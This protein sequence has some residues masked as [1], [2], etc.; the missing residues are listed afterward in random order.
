MR[1]LFSSS[2]SAAYPCGGSSTICRVYFH[3]LECLVVVKEGAFDNSSVLPVGYALRPFSLWRRGPLRLV[4]PCHAFQ[5]CT[6]QLRPLLL[7]ILTGTCVFSSVDIFYFRLVPRS[8]WDKC[9][10]GNGKWGN[11]NLMVVLNVTT[12]STDVI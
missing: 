5:V 12:T 4:L 8:L 11:V 2:G 1:G 10:R 7:L 6:L 9:F 3:V